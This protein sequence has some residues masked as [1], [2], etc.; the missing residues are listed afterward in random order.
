MQCVACGSRMQLTE[1]VLAGISTMPGFERHTFKCFACPQTATR[2]VVSRAKM[3]VFEPL[4]PLAASQSAGNFGRPPEKGSA[5][6]NAAE[7]PT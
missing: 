2:L 1:V 4:A 5:A 3:A 7:S 6:P